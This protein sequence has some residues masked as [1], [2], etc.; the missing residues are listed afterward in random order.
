M[1]FITRFILLIVAL[2]LP[3]FALYTYNNRATTHI[4]DKQID[5][6]NVTRMDYFRNQLDD[7]ISNT[8]KF[9]FNL[10]SD[11]DVTFFSSRYAGEYGYDRDQL[12][13]SLLAKLRLLNGYGHPWNNQILLYFPSARTVLSNDTVDPFDED[14][15]LQHAGKKWYFDQSKVMG[16]VPRNV[17]TRLYASPN[18]GGERILESPVVVGVSLSA[19]NIVAMLDAFK[20]TGIN[21]PFIFKPGEDVIF[22][23][24]ADEA[25]IRQLIPMLGS[26]NETNGR[27]ILTL[28]GKKYA[29]YSRVSEQLGWTLVD[30]VPL[31]EILGPINRSRIMFYM[32]LSFLL[33]LGIVASGMLFTQIQMP[34]QL[35]IQ[36]L[37]KL[38]GGKFSIRIN[39]RVR[40]EFQQVYDGF[41]EMAGEIQHLVE[42]V[43]LEEIRSKEAVMKQLQSQ[44]NPHFLYNCFAS[45]IGMA[46]L[47]H[48]DA[49]I[50]MSHNL[51]D[52]YKYA[53]RNEQLIATI[54]EELEFVENYLNIMNR[55][56][57][58]FDY[59]ISVEPGLVSVSIPRLLVQPLAE[60]AIIHGLEPKM[61]RG[62]IRIAVKEA[63][64]RISI[65][66]E[67]D[68]V[69]MTMEACRRLNRQLTG[70]RPQDG[71]VGLW[72]VRSR[73]AY[74][75]GSDTE[76]RVESR[77]GG[78]TSV[79]LSW[80]GAGSI[81]RGGS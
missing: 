29:V 80:Q 9:A 15:L 54:G 11:R 47:K 75:F 79:T 64:G 8:S 23:S 18:F 55:Q 68:G 34:L 28:A 67:D 61:G 63:A 17:F 10:T 45:L 56:L 37:H 53:T 1:R 76:F 32:T 30:Y 40:N 70:D 51:A 2:M 78:G 41:N 58:K 14:Y 35:L 39:S 73:L 25:T 13:N 4:I 20:S 48:N 22:N 43:Y 77:E 19:D 31:E 5:L 36:S 74:F 49:I 60:N 26:G 57:E 81:R 33:L 42:R 16:A 6:F 52:Y 24:S 7:S 50:A 21:D 38:K 72:N 3:I 66:V 62:A 44:I 12:Y 27:S 65:L 46:K 71:T 69:G 59:E